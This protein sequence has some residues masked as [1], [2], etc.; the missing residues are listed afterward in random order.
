MSRHLDLL[1]PEF[2]LKV[3][4]LLFVC[5][6]SGYPMR[7]FFT[8]RTPFEQG[9]LW[10]QSRPTEVVQNKI[11]ELRNNGA[12]FLAYCIESVGPQEGRHVTNATPGLSWHQW[13]EAVDCYW[14]LNGNSEWSTRKKIDGKNGYVNYGENAKNM[15]LNSGG[16]W[17]S[18]KDWPHVQLRS[19]SNPGKIFSLTEINQEM[20]TNFSNT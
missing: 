5:E 8:L 6:E 14:L 17:S 10:R 9:K 18:I 3:E 15:G 4:E 2:K 12:G 13:G 1:I 7:N 11:T 20:E 19:E 16:Y